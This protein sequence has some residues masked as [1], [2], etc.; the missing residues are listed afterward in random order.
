MQVDPMQGNEA[1][2]DKKEDKPSR[3]NQSVQMQ[4]KR[5]WT[6]TG[7][8]FQIEGARKT[9]KDNQECANR[10]P[11]IEGGCCRLT[12]PSCTKLRTLQGCAAFEGRHG[13]L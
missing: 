9:N 3:E 4:V 2:L 10:N 13:R 8:N 12:Y 7:Q 1:H 5:K 6:S 11:S